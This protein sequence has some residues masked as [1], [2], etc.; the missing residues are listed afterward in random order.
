VSLLPVFRLWV[1]PGLAALCQITL[2][3][4]L[5]EKAAS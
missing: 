5:A 1:Q 3:D 2:P 4:D